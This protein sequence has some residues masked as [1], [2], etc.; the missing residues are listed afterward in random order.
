MLSKYLPLVAA[1][2]LAHG[3]IAQEQPMRGAGAGTGS[4]IHD[5]LLIQTAKDVLGED[6]EQPVEGS[7]YLSEEFTKGTV[8]T[9]K[10]VFPDIEMRYNV[11]ADVIEFR[12]KNQ[13]YLLDPLPEI[14]RVDIGDLRL[15]VSSEDGSQRWGFYELLDS[16]AVMLMVRHRVAFQEGRPP[17][18]LQSKATPARYTRMPD[19]YLYQKAGALPTR[20][21]NLKRLLA[22]LPGDRQALAEFADAE[23]ISVRKKDDLVRL[24]RYCN[25]AVH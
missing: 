24:I 23:D 5:H 13:T 8:I 10:R 16:G 6:A 3:L 25:Q 4:N 2:S 9:G 19:M 21:T 15:V 1:L 22:D 11:H 14:V 12:Q 20:V 7:P 17:Q 18:A